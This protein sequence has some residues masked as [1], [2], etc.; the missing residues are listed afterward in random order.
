MFIK[1]W[2]IGRQGENI[3]L[4]EGS[5]IGFLVFFIIEMLQEVLQNNNL[6]DVEH[7]KPLVKPK[8]FT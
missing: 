5:V 8:Q 7:P 2:R 4:L 3:L 6:P 1:W